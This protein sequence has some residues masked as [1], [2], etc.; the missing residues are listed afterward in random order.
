MQSPPY[1]LELR[2]AQSLCSRLTKDERLHSQTWAVVVFRICGRARIPMVEPHPLVDE[3]FA[4]FLRVVSRREHH[5]RCHLLLP[6]KRALPE[7]N[8]ELQADGSDVLAPGATETSQK[9]PGFAECPTRTG[10]PPVRTLAL[11]YRGRLLGES[12]GWCFLCRCMLLDEHHRIFAIPLPF[13]SLQVSSAAGRAGPVVAVGDGDNWLSS[14]L[15]HRALSQPPVHLPGLIAHI[16][17]VPVSPAFELDTHPWFRIINQPSSM[18]AW[19]CSEC[20]YHPLG[21][22]A[23]IA[24]VSDSL[25][26]APVAV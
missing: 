6:N 24:I 9:F 14:S 1:T 17:P 10:G 13:S 5:H 8:R 2:F 26:R 19:H 15:F 12:S 3:P 4:P 21:D 7:L 23:D 25:P 11:G 20:R 18:A 16:Y 22:L